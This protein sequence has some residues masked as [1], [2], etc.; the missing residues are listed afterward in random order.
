MRIIPM[1]GCAACLMACATTSAPKP[2]TRPSGDELG[3]LIAQYEQEKQVAQSSAD[4][5]ET[6][7]Q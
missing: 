4:S 1:L 5:L 7:D 3:A 2:P 6:R